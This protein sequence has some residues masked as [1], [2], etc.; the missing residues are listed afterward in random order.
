M[1]QNASR[2]PGRHFLQIPGPTPVPDRVL[3]A[4]DMPLIDQRG[5][6]FAKLT[7]RPDVLPL[8]TVNAP[9][10]RYTGPNLPGSLIGAESPSDI[11]HDGVPLFN[12]AI[13]RATVLPRSVANYCADRRSI[14]YQK[15]IER[16]RMKAP[17]QS[18]TIGTK[19]LTFKTSC[20]SSVA[21]APAK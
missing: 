19:G 17:I 3:R 5:P 4:I 14:A 12:H 7:K 8:L 16:S 1:P 13:Q 18:S 2:L 9:L 6:E 11:N 20:D 10:R 15:K 21:I